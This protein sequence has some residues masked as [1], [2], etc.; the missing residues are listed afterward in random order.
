MTV[1]RD[2]EPDK[3]IREICIIMNISFQFPM[4]QQECVFWAAFE[5]FYHVTIKFYVLIIALLSPVAVNSLPYV[6]CVCGCDPDVN[7]I[8]Y[9]NIRPILMNN[10]HLLLCLTTGPHGVIR[11]IEQF[12]LFLVC[13]I[14]MKVL[15]LIIHIR[16][17][18]EFR[19]K[20]LGKYGCWIAT[21]IIYTSFRIWVTSNRIRIPL[22]AFFILQSKYITAMRIHSFKFYNIC[23]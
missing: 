14:L 4:V 19:N 16:Y 7:W 18:H 3:I 17:A 2:R 8:C 9:T 11:M 21:A 6:R 13:I 22:S 20:I 1:K 5:C 15:K 23:S 10:F 12:L